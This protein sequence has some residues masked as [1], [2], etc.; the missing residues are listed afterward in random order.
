M[1]GKVLVRAP[2]W[3]GDAVLSLPAVKAIRSH[4]ERLTVMA[5]PPA[6]GLYDGIADEVLDA[7]LPLRSAVAAVRK[8]GPD[9][10]VLFQNSFYSALVPRLAGC[11]EI[12]GYA[13]SGR[14]ILLTRR[15]R[16]PRDVYA[17]HQVYY[18]WRLVKALGLADGEPPAISLTPRTAESPLEGGA[19]WIGMSPGAKYGEAKR[20]QP[21]SYAA[22][23]R[24]LAARGYRVALFGSG[25][26]ARGCEEIAGVIGAAALSLAGK[27]DLRQLMAGIAACAVFVTNDSG[28]LHI[29]SALNVPLVAIFGSTEPRSTGPRHERSIV[30]R[31]ALPC[32]PC[33]RR[34]C[35]IDHRCMTR[36]HPEEALAAVLRLDNS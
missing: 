6:G 8:C 5:R 35:P 29:A 14:S 16:A 23:G 11:R 34:R 18:H 9:V 26:E 28:S 30:L 32:A 15:V 31:R 10:A 22:L 3:L 33:H 17:E 4:A 1:L 25:E 27:T 13:K 2:N 20:W 36:I 12:W 7:R 24:M 19:R 21:E